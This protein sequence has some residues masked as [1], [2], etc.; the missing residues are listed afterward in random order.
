MGQISEISDLVARLG[1]IAH[2]LQFSAGLN[3]AQWEALRYLDRANR[4]SRTPS[5][6]AAYMGTTKG[7]VSQ[8]LI[9]LEAKGY[10]ERTRD[11]A[12]RRSVSLV[13]TENGRDLL[14][15][16]PLRILQEAG[17]TLSAADGDAMRNGMNLLVG[18]LTRTLGRCEFGICDECRHLLSADGKDDVAAPVHCGFIGEPLSEIDLERICVNFQ[19]AH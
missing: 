2:T 14:G 12:D 4:Y 19:P 10:V 8:T 3:P 13:L 16:D 1:R 18:V 5:A 15:K 9:A 17:G 6:L 7:T 11:G